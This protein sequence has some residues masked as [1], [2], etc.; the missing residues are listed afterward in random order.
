MPD[1]SD[2]GLTETSA[3]PKTLSRLL[4]TATKSFSSDS[5][6]LISGVTKARAPPDKS[7]PVLILDL[8][9]LETVICGDSSVK[10]VISESL[11]LLL[12]WFYSELEKLSLLFDYNPQHCLLSF[13]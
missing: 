3:I 5:E 11:K 9:M 8:G 7:K 10:R 4:V 12:T 6:I 13:H 2:T 1:K